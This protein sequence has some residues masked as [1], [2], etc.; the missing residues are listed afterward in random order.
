MPNRRLVVMGDGPGADALRERATTNVTFLG[1][2]PHGQLLEHF[3]R[4]RAFLF[5][6]VEDFGITPLEAQAAGTPVIAFAG[7]ALPETIPDLDADEPCG[8]LF[9]AQ[10]PESVREAVERFERHADEITPEACR[11]NAERFS[12]ER[13]RDHF[14]AVLEE[15]LAEHRRGLTA[16]RATAGALDAGRYL[17]RYAGR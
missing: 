11:R 15:S 9:D 13:F 14:A 16:G 6:A 5:C 8:V 7:G 2:V 12:A 17:R 4:A 3:R 10:T 1:H